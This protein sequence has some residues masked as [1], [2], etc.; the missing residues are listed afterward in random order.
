MAYVTPWAY[1][2]AVWVFFNAMIMGNPL[3]FVTGKGSAHDHASML[4][5]T[6]ATMAGL[7]G[8]IPGSAMQTVRAVWDVSP[9]YLVMAPVSLLLAVARRDLFLLCMVIV[10][11]SFPAMQFLLY[12][13]GESLGWLRYHSY[14]AAFGVMVLAYVLRRLFFAR[15]GR[16]RQLATAALLAGLLGWANY[17]TWIN[18]EDPQMV[19]GNEQ[20]YLRATFLGAAGG[21]DEFPKWNYDVAKAIGD[22]IIAAEPNTLILLDDQQAND[23]VLFSGKPKH[24]IG[25]NTSVFESY[26]REPVGKV[27]HFLV[28]SSALIGSDLIH[29]AYPRIYEEGAP[30]A[31]LAREFNAGG[32]SWR[33]YRIAP[34]PDQQ[35]QPFV[36]VPAGGS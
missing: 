20:S 23:L 24:F 36:P 18:L 16:F 10:G 17:M 22:E 26:L 29:Q 11:L 15:T 3:Y 35:Q 13:R 33:L 2:F 30:F 12:W 8:N 9:I 19:G 4:L 32:M 7:V 34:P 31:T 5:A 1:A 28:P 21:A 25:P 27:T 14:V 6:N